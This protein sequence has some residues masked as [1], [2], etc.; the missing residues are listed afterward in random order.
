MMVYV[1]LAEYGDECYG[2]FSSFEKA[3]DALKHKSN[4]WIE[5]RELDN[6]GTYAVCSNQPFIVGGPNAQKGSQA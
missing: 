5:T 1:A 4:G 2:V 6:P 3:Q